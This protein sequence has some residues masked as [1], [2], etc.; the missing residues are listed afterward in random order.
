MSV[1]LLR[2]PVAFVSDVAVFVVKCAIA[3]DQPVLPFTFIA[4]S[5]GVMKLTLTMSFTMKHLTFVVGAILIFFLYEIKL[6][7]KTLPELLM[8]E[9]TSFPTWLRRLMLLSVHHRRRKLDG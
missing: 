9:R 3:V 4:A 1:E 8:R 7:L 5:I 2:Y 6:R